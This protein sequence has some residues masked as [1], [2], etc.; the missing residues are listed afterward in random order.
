MDFGKV[1]NG[2]GQLRVSRG[3][4]PI[5]TRTF[6]RLVIWGASH[7]V[8]Y[9][10]S[11]ALS[12]LL[13]GIVERV[14]LTSDGT[15]PLVPTRGAFEALRPFRTA[16]LSCIGHLST[17]DQ[18]TF[19][20]LFNGSKR[21]VYE[22][23]AGTFV[24][25]PTLSSEDWIIKGFVKVE[26]TD[27]TVKSDPA[28]RII[29]P[30][31]ARYNIE[32]GRY[33]KHNEKRFYKA[34]NSVFSCPYP[35]ILKG[36]NAVQRGQIIRSKWERF[37]DPVCIMFDASRFDQHVSIDALKWEHDIYVSAF[38]GDK[39]LAWLL[40]KQLITR[41]V[42]YCKDGKVT[43]TRGG[44]RCS[45]DMNTAL[46]NCLISAGIV[47]SFM[48]DRKY[49]AINDGDDCG[50]VVERLES[51]FVL[52]NLQSYCAHLGFNVKVE[53]PVDCLEHIE[54]CQCHPVFD[55]QGYRM[56]RSVRKVFEQDLVSTKVTN[57]TSLF[58]HLNAIRLGGLTLNDG[59]PVLRSFYESLPSTDGKVHMLDYGFAHL[60]KGIKYL[61][62]P[63]TP[64]A[65]VSFYL[66]FGILPDT[67]VMI[68][69]HF[70]KRIAK[71]KTV[72]ELQ[73]YQ[74]TLTQL[75]NYG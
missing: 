10:D 49:S 56:V 34:A 47:H 43:W 23:A 28:P 21:K 54:F 74:N 60:V 44:G 68:E 14:F 12:N 7:V 22:R 39:Y 17:L 9:Y 69:E 15:P 4:A 63:I 20:A 50:I 27:F 59:I 11:R 8:G 48:G 33:L 24:A 42:A 13:R 40:S 29:S 5:K 61:N 3:Y 18:P 2:G 66:A 30:R 62:A 31:N 67:Q 65:R 57:M 35:T 45:G 32:L 41:G 19:V 6:A 53:A 38:N 71:F 73:I 72:K 46:G 64:E 75:L 70:A 55:G 16:L 26:K 52:D 37:E 36:Y 58:G 25:K 1:E 51:G